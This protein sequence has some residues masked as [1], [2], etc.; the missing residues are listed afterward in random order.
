VN[1][2][3]DKA[4]ARMKLASLRQ[5]H[6]DLDSAIDAMVTVG[7]DFLQIQR[8]KRKKL[9]LKDRINKLAERVTPDIIA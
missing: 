7:R 3:Q 6:D 4:E 9:E 1:D 5:E 8:M 2:D